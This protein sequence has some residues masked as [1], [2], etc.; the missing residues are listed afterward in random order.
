MSLGAIEKYLQ[1]GKTDFFSK[2]NPLFPP[3]F[4]VQ[5]FLGGRGRT[6]AQTSAGTMGGNNSA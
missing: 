4:V 1:K 3:L 5:R 6:G 2:K